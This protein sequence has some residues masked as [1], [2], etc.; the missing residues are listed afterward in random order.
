MVGDNSSRLNDESSVDHIQ[1]EGPAKHY[2]IFVF[3]VFP[4]RGIPP[5]AGANDLK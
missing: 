3:G 4:S 1:N 5:L 2:D